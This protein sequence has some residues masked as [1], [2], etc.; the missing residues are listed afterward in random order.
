MRLTSLFTIVVALAVSVKCGVVVAESGE[1]DLSES[2]KTPYDGQVDP[3]FAHSLFLP[4][5]GSEGVHEGGSVGT[6]GEFEGLAK[7]GQLGPDTVRTRLGRVFKHDPVTLTER[8][9]QLDEHVTRLPIEA[10]KFIIY[11]RHFLTDN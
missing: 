2:L 9:G 11:F 5:E 3:T 1:G 8:L 4:K 6:L 7:A 10:C